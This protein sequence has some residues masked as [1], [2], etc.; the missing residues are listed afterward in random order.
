MKGAGPTVAVKGVP[1]RLSCIQAMV[2]PRALCG[3]RVVV[4]LWASSCVC[5]GG[6]RL[7]GRGVCPLS[8]APKSRVSAAE[9][10]ARWSN[11][12]HILKEWCTAT[13]QKCSEAPSFRVSG[14]VTSTTTG[15]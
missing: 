12:A 8:F 3:G 1:V 11:C 13:Q 9:D 10:G 4:G 6:G 2:L 15:I 7:R 5:T 14:M